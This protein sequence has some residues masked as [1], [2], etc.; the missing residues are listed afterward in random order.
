MRVRTIKRI[1]AIFTTL[2]R[3]RIKAVKRKQK[4]LA[5]RA[6]KIENH[7]VEE[8]EEEKAKR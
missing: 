6:P 4:G 7:N 5:K 2:S 1:K 3:T 8:Q